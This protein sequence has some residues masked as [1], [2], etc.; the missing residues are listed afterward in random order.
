MVRVLMKFTDDVSVP[1]ESGAVPQVTDELQQLWQELTDSFD[2]LILTPLAADVSLDDLRRMVAEATDRAEGEAV[3]DPAL[4]FGID[5]PDGALPDPNS[6]AGA[7]VEA[8]NA[9]SFVEL[10]EVE[11]DLA[12]AVNRAAN[13]AAL[14]QQYLNPAPVGLGTD[15]AWAV[16]GGD[17]TG[18]TVGVLEDFDLD[19]AHRDAPANRLDLTAAVANPGDVDADHATAVLGVLAGAD[20]TDDIVGFVPQARIAFA[21]GT[22]LT[23]VPTLPVGTAFSLINLIGV[24]LAAGDVLNLSLQIPD[25]LPSGATVQLPVESAGIVRT[26]LRLLNF[27][28]ITCVIAAGNTGI[29]LDAQGVA[30]PDSGA[31]VVGGVVPDIPP[32]AGAFH[33]SANS[34]TGSRIDCCAW[35]GDVTT[36]TTVG[37]PSTTV[38]TIPE[39][40]GGTSIATPMISGVV[41]AI[42]G[43]KK[44]LGAAPLP[45]AQ[46]RSLLRDPAVGTDVCPG[47]GVGLMPDLSL[48]MSTI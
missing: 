40:Q 48:I 36:L 23:G 11:R 30:F 28:G 13:P 3:P 35:A 31:V 21:S 44:A 15:A 37:A 14:F 41:A 10:A 38:Q 47:L 12:P 4:C 45:P 39:N 17:G 19:R 26:A 34:N 33:V 22:S 5:V 1:F 29:D 20:N 43:R 42:Q 8:L 32:V 25:S 2:F 6:A 18:V 27:R 24:Q 9:L 16:P 7:L 46:I